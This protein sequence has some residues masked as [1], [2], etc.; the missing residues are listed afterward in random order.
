MRKKAHI[1]A[2]NFQE[3]E[4]EKL[5]FGGNIESRTIW[6]EPFEVLMSGVLVNVSI[7]QVTRQHQGN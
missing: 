6:E 2:G 5:A 7:A 3:T 4:K 1:T